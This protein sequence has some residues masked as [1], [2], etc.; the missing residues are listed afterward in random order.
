MK[1]YIVAVLVLAGVGFVSAETYDLPSPTNITVSVTGFQ[2]LSA[3]SLSDGS[4]E[5]VANVVS[6]LPLSDN[7]ERSLREVTIKPIRV[8]VKVSEA[9]IATVLGIDVSADG[10]DALYEA[11]T[12]TEL[13][14]GVISACQLKVLAT[15]Q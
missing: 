2:M 15:V 13:R 9:E 8:T 10:W 4:W 5:I 6:D 11:K 3:N 7:D 14:I 1:K 12:I